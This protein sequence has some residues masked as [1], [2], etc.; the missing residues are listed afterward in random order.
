MPLYPFDAQVKIVF[1]TMTL[2]NFIQ[3]ENATDID[4]VRAKA[5]ELEFDEDDDDDLILDNFSSNSGNMNAVR[6][7]IQDELCFHN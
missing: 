3:I 7:H 6:H 1:A 2:H 4:F 5:G